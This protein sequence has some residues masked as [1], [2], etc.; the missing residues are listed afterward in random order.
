MVFLSVPIQLINVLEYTGEYGTELGVFIPFVH[1]LKVNNMLGNTKVITYKGMQPYY[2]FLD[3]NQYSEKDEQRQYVFP[4]NRWFLPDCL[5]YEDN[6]FAFGIIPQYFSPPDFFEA[7]KNKIA[8]LKKPLVIVHNKYCE[9]WSLPPLNFFDLEELREI[10]NA[11]GDKYHIVYFRTNNFKAIRSNDYSSDA[12]ESDTYTLND[13]EMISQSFPHVILIETFLQNNPHLSFNKAKCFLEAA[14]SVTI[15]TIG[16]YNFFDSYFPSKH[17]IYKK[18]TPDIYNASYY[19]TQH[20]ILCS[21][22]AKSSKILF[23]TS[24]TGLKDALNTL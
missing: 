13:K 7:Y 4:W 1:Y 2:F 6:L 14:A 21:I 17:I 15:S 18:R 10:F 24:L 11:F 23:A 9:E 5:K 20:D 3:D 19:Q 12:T 8:D 16:G 22:A